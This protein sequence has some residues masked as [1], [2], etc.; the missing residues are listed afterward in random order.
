MIKL[1]KVM[2]KSGGLVSF[3][4]RMFWTTFKAAWDNLITSENILSIFE[5]CGI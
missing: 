3:T 4:K 1:N 5:K 2:K